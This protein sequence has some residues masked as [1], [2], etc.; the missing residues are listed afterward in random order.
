MTV[1]DIDRRKFYLMLSVPQGQE[2]ANAAGFTPASDEVALRET[3]EITKKW[4][5][6]SQHGV[7]DSSI[8][9]AEWFYDVLV[10]S[11]DGLL[12]RLSDEEEDEVKSRLIA[13]FASFSIAM[14]YKMLSEGIT[15]LDGGVW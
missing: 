1:T 14:T 15:H 7:L 6:L 11:I 12:D 4:V 9:G 3:E 8:E 13:S 2:L 5:L 10:K